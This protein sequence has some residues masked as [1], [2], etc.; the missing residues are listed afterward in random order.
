MEE[1]QSCFRHCCSNS[2]ASEWLTQ[3]GWHRHP[4]LTQLVLGS[5]Y[6]CHAG[7]SGMIKVFSLENLTTFRDW[8]L[9]L[10][11]PDQSFSANSSIYCLREA[12]KKNCF[13]EIWENERWNLGRKRRFS[14]QF[15]F[16]FEGFGPCLGISH[17]THPHLGK[18]SPKKRFFFGS[19]P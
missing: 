16:F 17:P 3:N 2:V 15:V 6:T 11:F 14:G 8:N 13:C 10:V 18:I 19:F 1:T 4:R 5:Q 9:F 7:A 12:A